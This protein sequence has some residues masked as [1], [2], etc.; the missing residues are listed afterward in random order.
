MNLPQQRLCELLFR[1][2]VIQQPHAARLRLPV[3]LGVLV[4][5]REVAQR[6]DRVFVLIGALLQQTHEV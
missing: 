2:G 1:P 4:I 5:V 3:V 6:L